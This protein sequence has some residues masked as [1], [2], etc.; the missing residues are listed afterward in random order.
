MGGFAENGVG[1]VSLDVPSMSDSF[2]SFHPAIEAGAELAVGERNSVR[3][4]GRTGVLHLGVSPPMV[5]AAFRGAPNGVATFDAIS[6]MDRNYAD[7]VLGID[8]LRNRQSLFRLEGNGLFGSN[9]RAWGVE[10][11]WSVSFE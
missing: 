7:V 2:L 4:Y 10:A 3:V 9:T 11:S 8:V 1:A 5:S 6:G